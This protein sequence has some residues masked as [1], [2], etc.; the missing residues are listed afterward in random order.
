[1]VIPDFMLVYAQ[2][3]GENWQ[4]VPNHAANREIEIDVYMTE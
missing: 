1:M 4:N 2:P 3:M